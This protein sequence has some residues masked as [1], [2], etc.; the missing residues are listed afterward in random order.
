M[1]GLMLTDPSGPSSGSHLTPAP[2][3]RI[4]PASRIVAG[5][6]A[7]MFAGGTAWSSLDPRMRAL[8]DRPGWWFAPLTLGMSAIFGW[9]SVRGESPQWLERGRWLSWFWW[10]LGGGVLWRL[11]R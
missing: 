11:F 5:L 3:Q 10:V 8:P 6:L 2:R 4:G 7:M 9:A 1:P